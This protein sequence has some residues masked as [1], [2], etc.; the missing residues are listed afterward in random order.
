MTDR[1]RI[2]KRA[3]G[4]AGVWRTVDDDPP[5]DITQLSIKLGTYMNSPN[6]RGETIFDALRFE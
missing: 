6:A 4:S 2:L 5:E 3:F 1:D